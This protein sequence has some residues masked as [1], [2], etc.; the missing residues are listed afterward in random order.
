MDLQTFLLKIN[1]TNTVFFKIYNMKLKSINGSLINKALQ[2]FSTNSIVHPTSPCSFN[3]CRISYAMITMS[4]PKEAA[5]PYPGRVDAIP[6][7]NSNPAPE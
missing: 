3:N 1:F 7:L 4:I 5:V 6:E 2:H